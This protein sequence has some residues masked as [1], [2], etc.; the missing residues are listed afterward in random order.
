MVLLFWYLL[1]QSCQKII[2]NLFV[3]NLIHFKCEMHKVAILQSTQVQSRYP[4]LRSERKYMK[5]LL[6]HMY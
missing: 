3:Q 1:P 5:M 6:S 2:H 4:P